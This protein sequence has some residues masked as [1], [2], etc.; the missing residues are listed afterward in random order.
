LRGSESTRISRGM[1]GCAKKIAEHTP[2]GGPLHWRKPGEIE[3]VR[4]D[5]A[6]LRK[7]TVGDRGI[8]QIFRPAQ[9]Q[10]KIMMSLAAKS[11]LRDASRKAISIRSSHRRDAVRFSRERNFLEDFSRQ[12]RLRCFARFDTTL[13]KLPR[14][15]RV[16]TFTDQDASSAVL[17]DGCDRGAISSQL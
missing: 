15:G 16:G 14:P 2:I 3:L 12:R 11:L 1:R 5:P 7:F 8:N 6:R 13:R 10:K 4:T 17:H 9:P